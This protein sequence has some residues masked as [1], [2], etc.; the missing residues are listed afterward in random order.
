MKTL[1]IA[2]IA[3]AIFVVPFV[4]KAK[5]D[6]TLDANPTQ[7]SPAFFRNE[8]TIDV[9]MHTSVGD[10]QCTLFAGKHQITVAN[11]L[12]LALG[13]IPWRDKNGNVHDIPYFTNL[14]FGRREQGAFVVS[15]GHDAKPDF[16]IPDGRCQEHPPVA[17][18]IAMISPW[19]GQ[20]STQFMILARDLPIFSGMYEVFGSCHDLEVIQKLTSEHATL[21]RIELKRDSL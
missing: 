17:G 16:T 12:A 13:M 1:R 10:L 11:F 15:G 21:D 3:L 18:A 2:A 6:A 5:D 19:P 14:D 20:A 8:Q 7:T 4:A 9:V